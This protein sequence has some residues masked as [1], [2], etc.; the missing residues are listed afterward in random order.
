[1]CENENK[2]N[3]FFSNGSCLDWLGLLQSKCP[4]VQCKHL[5]FNGLE[6]NIERGC[7]KGST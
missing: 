5:N 4:V 1:M 3:S 2:M 7:L 6:K